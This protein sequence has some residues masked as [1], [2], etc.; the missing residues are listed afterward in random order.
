[1]RVR[2][3]GIKSY[4]DL[5]VWQLSMDLVEDLYRMTDSLPLSERFGLQSQIRRAGCSIP[6]NIAEGFQGRSRR[7]YLRHLAIANGSLAEV[8]TSV[9]IAFRVRLVPNEAV[10]K[11]LEVTAE[12]GRMLWGL[13]R[14]LSPEP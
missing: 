10:T 5:R 1:M 8:E 2:C 6:A 9:L 11:V 3:N 14:A 4:R 13:R 12:V 7:E